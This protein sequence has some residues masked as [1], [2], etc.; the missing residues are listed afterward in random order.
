MTFQLPSRD[1]LTYACSPVFLVRNVVTGFETTAISLNVKTLFFLWSG[2][3]LVQENR[4]LFPDIF[5]IPVTRS[6][7]KQPQKY[8]RVKSIK[9]SRANTLLKTSLNTSG[10]EVYQQ[11][12]DRRCEWWPLKVTPLLVGSAAYVL[13]RKAG[14]SPQC[15][16]ENWQWGFC[17]ASNIA[18]L[19]HNSLNTVFDSYK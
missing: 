4:R 2:K 14:F 18:L 7:R 11:I 6:S 16:A 19:F 10:S 13:P 3:S 1:P 12:S 9:Y 8:V 17:D 15:D 5:L